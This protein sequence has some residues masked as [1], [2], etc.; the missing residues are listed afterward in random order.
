MTK[1]IYIVQKIMNTCIQNNSYIEKRKES[2]ERHT[3]YIYHSHARVYYLTLRI[4]IHI[5]L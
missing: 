5:H 1:I 2:I 4:Y 3:P